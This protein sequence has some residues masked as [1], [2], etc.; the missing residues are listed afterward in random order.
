[1]PFDFYDCSNIGIQHR[2]TSDAKFV[3]IGGLGFGAVEI[4]PF[5]KAAASIDNDIV[6]LGEITKRMLQRRVIKAKSPREFMTF[7][8]MVDGSFVEYYIHQYHPPSPSTAAVPSPSSPSYT[9]KLV[10]KCTLP[11]LSIACTHMMLP[12]EYL[13]Y[14]K[15]LIEDSLTRGSDIDKP[16]LYSPIDC[17]FTPT[18]TLLTLH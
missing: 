1:V 2:Q 18:V 17:I 8:V 9:F 5:R 11:T 12:L 3:E 13:I 4:E 16:Y 15:K 6:R 7:G 14:Y 10:Q